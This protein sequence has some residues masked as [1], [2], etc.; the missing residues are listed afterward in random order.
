MLSHLRFLVNSEA[1]ERTFNEL[2]KALGFDV[3]RPDK[4]WKEGPDNL[5]AL[6]DTEYLLV[7]CKNEV[8]L[9]RAEISKR[10]TGQMNNACA[11]FSK[12]YRGATA[13]NVLVI[14]TKKVASARWIQ[15]RGRGYAKA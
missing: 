1:F 14:P 8:S 9:D 11:W 7:E 12:N 3:Q 15:Q 6:R 13:K 4:E 2:G 10:E 5:W